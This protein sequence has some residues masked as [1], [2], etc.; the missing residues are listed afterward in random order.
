MRTRHFVAAD[1]LV[2]GADHVLGKVHA[3]G[4]DEDFGAQ[5]LSE[6]GF[7]GTAGGSHDNLLG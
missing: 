2:H 6:F 4:H 7:G 1:D 3:V 5:N